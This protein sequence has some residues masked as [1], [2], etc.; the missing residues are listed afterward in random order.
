MIDLKF[1]YFQLVVLLL[2][3]Y[4]IQTLYLYMLLQ[5]NCH[6]LRLYYFLLSTYLIGVALHYS[7]A[8]SEAH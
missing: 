2:K 5:F 6:L 4:V 7:Y 1:L 3:L 8:A